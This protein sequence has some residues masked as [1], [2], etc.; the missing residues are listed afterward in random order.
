MRRYIGQPLPR[1]E[2]PRLL[3]GRGCYTDDVHV[4]G[5]AYCAFLRSP[6][7]H[8][9][10]VAIDVAEARRANGVLAV[11]TGADYV[12]DGLGPM[13]HQAN[14]LDAL[15]VSKRAF[16]APA[17]AR[18]IELPH[19]PLARAR[20]RHVGEP[21]AAVIATTAVLARDAVELIHVEYEPLPAVVSVLDS[22]R[23]PAPQLWDEVPNNECLAIDFGD[24]DATLRAFAGARHIV[25]H[26]FVNQ[27]LAN[28]QMEPR[29][30]IGHYD[31]IEKRFTLTSGSQGVVRQ[32]QVLA[33]ALNV[34]LE[35]VRVVSP[36]V[37]GGFGPR[38]FLSPEQVVVA[39][40]AKRVGRA[41][42]WTSD[43]SEAFVSD[44]QARDSVLRAALALDVE[45]RILGYEAELFGNIGAHT[46][47]F[48][49]MANAQRILT[50]VYH[51]PAAHLRVRGL[52]TNTVPTSPYRGAGRPEATHALERLLDMAARRIGMDRI[53][54]RR[55]NLIHRAQLPY[56]SVMGLSYD[57]GDFAGYMD[58]VLE[59]AQ[60]SSFPAR[61]AAARR[62][63]R[64]AGIGFANY[65]ESPVGAPRERAAVT[66][67]GSEESE[68][69]EVIVGTQTTGQGHETS[70]AQVIADQ[71]GVPFESIRIRYGDTAFVKAGGGTHS[72][73][74]MRLVG[75]LLVEAAGEIIK[76]GREAAASLLEAATADLSFEDGRYRVAGI[77]RSVGLFDV[78]RA[79]ER[80]SVETDRRR[81]LAGIGD[82]T[83]R[84][85]AYPA[86]AA[87]CE[88]EIDPETGSVSITRY[89]TVDDVGQPINP[90]ILDGQTHGGIAQGAGQALRESVAFDRDTGQLLAGSF[91]DYGLTR[92]DELPSFE[93]ELAEDPTAGNPLRVKGGGEGGIVPATAAIVNALCDALAEEGIEDLPMPASAEVIWRAL[94][95]SGDRT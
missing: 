10:I 63:G 84:M 39:W 86:G 13:Q 53:E 69:V 54:L 47:S 71:L 25:R 16:V 51:V 6:H 66:V 83:G 17:G 26:E 56:R 2:D 33:A 81:A 89:T 28:C 49:P 37:G 91:M 67:L 80:S 1:V 30:A 27:R 44:Y 87:V 55:R 62:R 3:T 4:E 29:S 9:R 18:I 45:G 90:L 15:D 92:A 22:A 72:D 61:Q 50:T 70:F 40:A 74:S 19:W 43:R 52:V 12:A 64:R 32:Q 42:K 58:R 38:S 93:V 73:R 34:S 57:S 5:K 36:D 48:V 31:P 95:H 82:F 68:G 75:S 35:Q 76:Q 79:M 65:V 77:D 46:V 11:L 7:A 24:A 41:V 60:W 8:A 23:D 85:P 94:Q 21:I 78:A 59:A 88:L 20:A 14:P